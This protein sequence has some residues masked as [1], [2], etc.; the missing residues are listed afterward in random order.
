MIRAF[1]AFLVLF[2][3]A[4][5]ARAEDTTAADVEAYLN[6]IR[7]LHAR[8]I[9][10]ANDG[11]QAAGDFYLHRPGRMRFQYDPPSTD[12]IVSDGLFVYYY[13]GQMKQQSNA[14]I[15]KSLADFF[16]R[17]NLTLSGDI[18]VSEIRRAGGLLQVTLT[19]AKAPL[20]GTLT[21]G[22]TEKPLALK[23]WRVVDAQ[24]AI[25]EVE[26]FD[27]E[28]GITL[29]SELFKYYDPTNK[30]SKYN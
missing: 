14:P 15:G 27:V 2:F 21:L 23:K 22:L 25:T 4:L 26:L 10:T 6:G 12:F 28:T 18:Q 13:D 20:A 5:P 8:F 11:R 7:T 17:K 3:I 19:Q 30:N 1:L 29:K 16:L 24:G 9:Q